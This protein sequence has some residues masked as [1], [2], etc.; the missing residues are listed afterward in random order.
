[1]PAFFLKNVGDYS[2][3]AKFSADARA[4][5]VERRAH[6]R[7]PRGAE[8]RHFG[9]VA[10]LLSLSR[11]GP[12]KG[13]HPEKLLSIIPSAEAHDRAPRRVVV[14]MEL[15]DVG[16]GLVLGYPTDPNP[17]SYS[18]TTGIGGIGGISDP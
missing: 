5:R 15:G 18:I 11:I 6:V 3:E 17:S 1:M 10:P 2:R 13:G 4:G 16:E 8:P 14:P 7:R 12:R 9:R